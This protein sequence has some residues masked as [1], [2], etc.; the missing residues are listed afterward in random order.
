MPIPMDDGW[1]PTFAVDLPEHMVLWIRQLAPAVREELARQL[2]QLGAEVARR[3]NENEDIGTLYAGPFVLEYTIDAPARTLHIVGVKS[4]HESRPV[5]V[6]DDDPST[7][8]GMCEL[9]ADAGYRSV[10]AENGAVA[11]EQ[12]KQLHPPPGLVVL[13]LMMPVM[14]GW[15]FLKHV[16]QTPAWADIPVLVVSGSD[17]RPH[18]VHGFLGK[19]FDST[20][21]L[22][23]VKRHCG[24]A[25]VGNID[26]KKL[27]EGV[28]GLYL[29]LRPD[30]TIVAVSDA[31]LKATMTRRH[32]ILGRHLFDVFPDNP[33]D[34]RADGVRNLRASLDRVLQHRK[35]D[36]MP[37]QKYDIRRPSEEGG[38]FE[39]RWWSPM[40]SPILGPEGQTLYIVHQVED[41]T[42]FVRLRE[43]GATEVKELSQRAERFEAEMFARTRELEDAKKRS[44]FEQLL[45]GIV[46]HDL[47]NPIQTVMTG[48][49]TLLRG[50]DL[51]APGRRTL[52][53]VLTA[54]QRASRLIRDLLDFT[55]ARLGGR[56]PVRR[57]PA[58][59]FE[60]IE[61]VV[62]ELRAAYADRTLIYSS[63]GDGRGCWD[64]D[65]LAQAVTNLVVNALTYGPPAMPVRIAAAGMDG[66]VL[67]DVH[68]QGAAIPAET[69]AKL[70]QPLQ[71]GQG[72]A[73]SERSIGLGLYISQQIAYAHNGRITVQSSD[74]EGTKFTLRLPRQAT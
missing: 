74:E 54:A 40:N 34:P 32:L 38:A 43:R 64:L 42:E 59:L 20:R 41:V 16:Q 46:S 12:L 18:L 70:F 10:T 47:R 27:F 5:L 61:Q 11:L 69:M 58:D 67:L 73:G 65:R 24:E 45:I 56:I 1:R 22:E 49:S 19:P 33:D 62:N 17:R 53:R 63:V 13:D 3:Q 7:R 29:V 37:L 6:V 21:L 23:M 39:E 35:A 44:E 26:F 68:N 71:R 57:V 72:T 28:P 25:V 52:V 8:A 4:A 55:Q 14:D 51:P 36:I 48:V 60:H 9:L 66:E 50:D 15:Q 31:Y 2:E 30:L